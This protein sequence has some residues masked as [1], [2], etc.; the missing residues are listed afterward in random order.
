LADGVNATDMLTQLA[1]D[2]A[3]L[4]AAADGRLDDPVP[5]CPGWTVRDAVEHTA[6]VYAHK[7]AIIEGELD[8]PPRP[9]PPDFGPVDALDL[10]DEQ[11]RRLLAALKSR[12]PKTRVWTWYEPDQSVGFWI[13][14]M[15]QET[16]VHRAD[17]ESASR[18]PSTVA[19]EVAIDGI[20]ELLERMVCYDVEA[21]AEAA[22][23]G[24]RVGVSAGPASWTLLLG[25][26]R[27]TLSNGIDDAVDATVGGPPGAVLLA[28]WNRAAYDAIETGGDEAT[29][30]TLRRVVATTTQ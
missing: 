16:V 6:V 23:N 1:A 19:D 7:A 30:A 15:M 17:V 2:G 14:R 11:F 28:L 10:F 24:Q 8:A 3:A 22:G 27:A 20:D 21:Y 29:L 13:R 5:T 26:E 18:A 25:P 9:W 12:D 4:R